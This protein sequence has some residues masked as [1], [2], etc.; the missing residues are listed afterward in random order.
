MSSKVELK[1]DI[2]KTR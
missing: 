1:E 2:E